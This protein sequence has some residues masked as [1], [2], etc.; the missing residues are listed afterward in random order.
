ME[1]VDCKEMFDVIH[2]LGH[3]SEKVACKIFRQILEAIKYM[4]SNGVC[5]RDLKPNNI[6]CSQGF[7]NIY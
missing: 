7:I 6:L 2:E 3:Y 1:F 5:H 4:H